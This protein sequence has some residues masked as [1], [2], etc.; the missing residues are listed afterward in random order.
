[1]RT[2]CKGLWVITEVCKAA[3]QQ[4]ATWK[5][6]AKPAQTKLGGAALVRNWLVLNVHQQQA[7]FCQNTRQLLFYFRSKEGA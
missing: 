7:N 6:L 2:T 3:Q 4:S 1:M 5:S